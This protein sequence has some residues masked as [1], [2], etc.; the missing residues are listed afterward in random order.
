MTEWLELSQASRVIS[1]VTNSFEPYGPRVDAAQ[2]GDVVVVAA[3]ADEHVP[4]ADVDAG[5]WGRSRAT[6]P[7]NHSTHAC[8]SPVTVSPIAASGCGCR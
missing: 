6:R 2:R 4:V 8:D 1:T 5:W 7:Q 3:A